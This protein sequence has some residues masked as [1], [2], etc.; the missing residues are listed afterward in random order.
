MNTL[1]KNARRGIKYK[2]CE[3]YL[4]YTNFKGDL[5]EHKCL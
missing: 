2:D 5:V 4:K 3:C 1:I